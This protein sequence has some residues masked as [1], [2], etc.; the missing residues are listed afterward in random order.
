M[1]SVVIKINN[2]Y[3]FSIIAQNCDSKHFNGAQSIF[4][5]L[6]DLGIYMIFYFLVF[7]FGIFKISARILIFL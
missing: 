1:W 7:L 2:R 6:I 4:I 3:N 5:E